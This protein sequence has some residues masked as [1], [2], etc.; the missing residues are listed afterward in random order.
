MNVEHGICILLC[1][2]RC[3]QTV[4]LFRVENFERLD[5]CRIREMALPTSHCAGLVGVEFPFQYSSLTLKAGLPV[6]CAK[7]NTTTV[8]KLNA[9]TQVAVLID[10]VMP[11]E[12]GL[13]ITHFEQRGE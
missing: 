13:Y 12:S 1:K 5:L 7:P 9:L 2:Q 3:V 10:K 8:A 6:C 11:H 4:F